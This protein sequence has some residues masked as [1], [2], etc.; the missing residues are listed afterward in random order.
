MTGPTRPSLK[1]WIFEKIVLKSSEVTL[2]PTGIVK[3]RLTVSTSPTKP[4][5][6]SI[7]LRAICT[8]VGIRNSAEPGLGNLRFARAPNH[9]ADVPGVVFCCTNGF[10]HGVGLIGGDDG[11]HADAHVEHLIQLV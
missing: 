8:K 10:E 4:T 3:T 11:D 7:H 6:K 9:L 1:S 2:L 5:A